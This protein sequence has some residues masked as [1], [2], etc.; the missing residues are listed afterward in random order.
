MDVSMIVAVQMTQRDPMMAE[1]GCKP[2]LQP[3][4]YIVVGIKNAQRVSS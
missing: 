2:R 4:T 3:A 1:A